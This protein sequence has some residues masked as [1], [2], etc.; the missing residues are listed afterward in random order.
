MNEF[1]LTYLVHFIPL[2]LAFVLLIVT[3]LDMVRFIFL[4][5]FLTGLK[6]VASYFLLGTILIFSPLIVLAVSLAAL[7]LMAGLFGQKA[8][9]EDYKVFLV[10]MSMFP[11][12]IGFWPS[13]MFVVLLIAFIGIAT[14][15]SFSKAKKEWGVTGGTPASIMLEVGEDKWNKMIGGIHFISPAMLAAMVTAVTTII[16]TML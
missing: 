5:I 7:F 11:W 10:I 15:R 9:A 1:V 12:Y 4:M 8:G 6:I 13:A 2:F 3:K 16:T 14:Y